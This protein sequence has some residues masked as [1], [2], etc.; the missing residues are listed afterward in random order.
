MNAPSTDIKD[1]L[2][3]ESAFDLVFQTNL[4]IGRRPARPRDAVA[5]IDTYGF[6]DDLGLTSKGY[7]RPSVQIVVRN[8]DYDVGMQLAQ[9][10]K[11]SLHGREHQTWNGTLYT[12]I[13]CLGAPALLG[14]DEN[15]VV[16]FSINFNLQRRVA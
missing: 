9:D 16:S 1:M 13:T 15:D 14:W 7:Q 2:V 6:P 12:V 10:I 4:F 8:K 5:I 11:D 3:A